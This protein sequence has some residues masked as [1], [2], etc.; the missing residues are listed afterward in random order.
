MP[1]TSTW[2]PRGRCAEASRQRQCEARP[3]LQL[4]AAPPPL[5][6][7]PPA[8]PLRPPTIPLQV[9]LIDFNPVGGTTAPLL[10]T[11]E[12]L[13]F[14]QEEGGAAGEAAS[15][16]AGEAGAAAEEA[17]AE[18]AAERPAAAEPCGSGAEQPAAAAPDQEYA[19][20]L[21]RVRELALVDQCGA[22]SD[23]GQ[24]PGR[25]ASSAEQAAEQQASASGAG[26]STGSSPAAASTSAAAAAAASAAAAAGVPWLGLRLISDPVALRPH[27][28]AY[29]VP[30][31]FADASEG[32]ALDALLKQAGTGAEELFA[33]LQRAAANGGS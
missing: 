24:R 13:G 10:F 22:A 7:C 11:W 23:A 18:E 3:A 15:E 14:G 28:L 17:A 9:R 2:P 4:G 16:A 1:T 12:E 30:Y 19:E 33:E 21:R 25:V 8:R 31:D 29:G 6:C 20:Q 5:F 32:S 26:G 27:K